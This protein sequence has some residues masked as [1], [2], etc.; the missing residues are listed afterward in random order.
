MLIL[1]LCMHERL[2][3]G[4]GLAT[5]M[6]ES[7]TVQSDT[8]HPSSPF[9]AYLTY[10]VCRKKV[11]IRKH[12]DKCPHCKQSEKEAK[13]S[14]N[15]WGRPI[16]KCQSTG[17]GRLFR[18]LPHQVNDQV[19]ASFTVASSNDSPMEFLVATP[20]VPLYHLAQAFC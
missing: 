13:C 17:A 11:G 16:L 14:S 15:N 12:P 8:S 6:V 5:V 20:D 4:S 10:K 3:Y 7:S 1:N 18:C 19:A 2:R 9:L